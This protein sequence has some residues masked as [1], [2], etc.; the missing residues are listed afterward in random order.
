MTKQEEI[1]EGI[2]MRLGIT[3]TPSKEQW[4]LAFTRGVY[5]RWADE[6]LVYLHSQGVELKVKCPHCIRGQFGDEVIGVSPCYHCNSEGYI[7]ESL[8]P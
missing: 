2:A 3:G 7:M 1:R 5:R 4:D 8:I 6:L